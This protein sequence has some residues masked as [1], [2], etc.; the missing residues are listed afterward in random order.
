MVFSKTLFMSGR[1]GTGIFG[2][3]NP[4]GVAVETTVN[5]SAMFWEAGGGNIFELE[6]AKGWKTDVADFHI[7]SKGVLGWAVNSCLPYIEVSAM[8][9]YCIEPRSF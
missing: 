6:V 4:T 5:L 1:K 2:Y 9:G 7:L 8:I 3:E